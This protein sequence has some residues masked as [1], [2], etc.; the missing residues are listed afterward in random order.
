MQ[1]H[2][3]AAKKLD[4]WS[5]P[6]FLIIHLK[7]FQSVNGGW[8]KSHR[9]V[10]FPIEGFDPKP[11]SSFKVQYRCVG[12]S[13]TSCSMHRNRRPN[14]RPNQHQKQLWRRSKSL[15]RLMQQLGQRSK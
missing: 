5:L 15:P 11:L 12:M 1:K 2:Q 6:P 8:R 9:E 3:P 10:R 4:I 14:R 13:L 7:R